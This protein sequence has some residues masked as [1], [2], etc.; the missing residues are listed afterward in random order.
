MCLNAAYV[1]TLLLLT[2]NSRYCPRTC[3]RI[4]FAYQFFL[5]IIIANS[6]TIAYFESICTLHQGGSNNN[7]LCDVALHFTNRWQ[8]K[9]L[10]KFR[11]C[12]YFQI[13]GQVEVLINKKKEATC[14]V[15]GMTIDFSSPKLVCQSIYNNDIQ[16]LFKLTLIQKNST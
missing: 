10:A 13:L 5:T 12:G 14:I 7:R 4:H 8:A 2:R 15:W 1:L 3:R 6:I 16:I 11:V 9:I